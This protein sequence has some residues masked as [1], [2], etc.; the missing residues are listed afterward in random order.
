MHVE[1]FLNDLIASKLENVEMSFVAKILTFDRVKMRATIRP[2]LSAT[3]QSGENA[4]RKT[5]NTPD[6]QDVPVE[7]IYA[8]GFYVRPD[9]SK[10]DLVR[11]SCYASSIQQP[12][13]SDLRTES[14]ANR[15][16]LNYCTVS[17]GI[18][19]KGKPVPSEWSTI[20][21][22]IIGKSGIHI[23][24]DASGVKVKG[25]F[26]VTG[27]ISATGDISAAN[28]NATGDV[29]VG[30]GPTAISLRNH[31]HLSSS[32]GNPTGPAIP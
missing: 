19:P 27:N 28:V 1:L 21:G 6:L 30:T 8:G 16:Q 20:S 9:Y 29:V 14:R 7:L 11:V 26:Q 10:G 2:M 22:L 13:E 31:K 23:S 24:F 4:T 25:N 17:S 15:F 32:P 5:V 3:T 12:I 18:V